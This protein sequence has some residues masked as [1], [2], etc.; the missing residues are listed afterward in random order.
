MALRNVSG[1]RSVRAELRA[2]APPPLRALRALIAGPASPNTSPSSPRLRFVSGPSIIYNATN[3]A[4]YPL[5][6]VWKRSGF[7]ICATRNYFLTSDYCGAAF[8]ALGA[9][10]RRMVSTS[11]ESENTNVRVIC[12][13]R[14][15]NAMELGKAMVSHLSS[16]R[17]KPSP[18]LASCLP[19][20]TNRTVF[21]HSLIRVV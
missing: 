13:V 9:R 8:L 14:P 10:R 17:T 12:R 15:P 3:S 2:E 4:A 20:L 21:P 7:V 5:G 18:T 19:T 16:P 11:G 1:S 6:D